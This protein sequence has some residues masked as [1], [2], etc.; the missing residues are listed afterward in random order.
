MFTCGFTTVLAEYDDQGSWDYIEPY[1]FGAV[2][3]GENFIFYDEYNGQPLSLTWDEYKSFQIGAGE[4]DIV[5]DLT[6]MK[7]ILTKVEPT[8]TYIRGDVDKSGEVKIGDVTALINYLLNGDASLVDL[9]AA[10]CDLNGEW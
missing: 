2:A 7:V 4:Y 9:N 3:D 10:D 5:V 6:N 8:P 1:R